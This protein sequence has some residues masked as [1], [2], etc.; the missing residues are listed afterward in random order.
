MSSLGFTLAHYALAVQNLEYLESC[1]AGHTKNLQVGSDVAKV[2]YGN[3][4]G[5]KYLN[6][7]QFDNV[8]LVSCASILKLFNHQRTH[9]VYIP[10]KFKLLH[11]INKNLEIS[12]NFWKVLEPEYFT[13]C[14]KKLEKVP[15]CS[16]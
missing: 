7:I 5:E 1:S 11:G 16:G 8:V 6:E 14:F 10:H 4:G 2:P 15:D 3:Q 9:F 13:K 12:R